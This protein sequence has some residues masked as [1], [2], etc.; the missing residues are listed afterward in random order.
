MNQ[1][2][3][4]VA[5]IAVRVAAASPALDF[6]AAAGNG[7]RNR[8][9]RTFRSVRAPKSEASIAKPKSDSLKKMLKKRK[10]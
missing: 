6:P 10:F 4:M 8:R 3:G 7:K 2:M 5:G 1:L 9:G